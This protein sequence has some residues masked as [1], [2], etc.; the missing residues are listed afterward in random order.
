MDDESTRLSA[1]TYAKGR[2]DSVSKQLE[3]ARMKT[4]RV[5]AAVVGL[6]CL[7]VDGIGPLAA[8]ADLG[9]DFSTGFERSPNANSNYGW[10]FTITSS[11]TIDG[12]GIWDAGSNGL[13]EPHDVGLWLTSTPIPEGVLVRSA[14]VSNEQ[15]VAV[16]SMSPSG[17]WLFSNVPAVTLNPGTYTVGALYRLGPPGSYDPFLSESLTIMTVPGVQ[18]GNVR[19]IHNTPNLALPSM[20]GLNEHQGFFGP[21]FRVVVPEPSGSSAFLAATAGLLLCGRAR[22]VRHE[23]V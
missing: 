20:V 15:S 17:R 22:M 2:V 7:A 23:A 13:I 10:S 3:N 9:L 8:T 18:Y 16:G 5:I 19:E 1:S 21:N 4:C 12:L 11:I 14:T 6:T